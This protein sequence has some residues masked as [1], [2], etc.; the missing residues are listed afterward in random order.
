MKLIQ[1]TEGFVIESNTTTITLTR[2]DFWTIVRSAIE[3]ST[4]VE[5]ED[6]LSDYQN[7]TVDDILGSDKLM[8]ELANKVI[9]IRGGNETG[10]DIYDAMRAILGGEVLN[11]IFI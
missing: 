1:T 8:S 4:K 5:I 11:K 2:S 3:F 6:Y 7:Y 10:D 9:Y